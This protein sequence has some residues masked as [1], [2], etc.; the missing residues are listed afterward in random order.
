MFQFK[1]VTWCPVLL[2]LRSNKTIP[3]P[4]S[5]QDYSWRRVP[6]G[7]TLPD[8]GNYDQSDK[9]T[10]TVTK[11]LTSPPPVSLFSPRSRQQSEWGR[12]S[13]LRPHCPSHH[14]LSYSPW[15]GNTSPLAG[16][17]AHIVGLWRAQTPPPTH[18][19][20]NPKFWNQILSGLKIVQWYFNVNILLCLC[21]LKDGEGVK[22]SCLPWTGQGSVSHCL[23]SESATSTRTK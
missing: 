6:G 22:T 20:G 21:P 8:N 2:H 9:V 16:P 11:W 4:T 19:Q 13:L 14:R 1:A 7:V 23:S 3:T 17:G 18:Q 15:C 5:Y 10:R 12:M